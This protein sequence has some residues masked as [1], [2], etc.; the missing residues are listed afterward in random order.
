MGV[1]G[2]PGASLRGWREYFPDA[3]IYG[4]D[5]DRRILFEEKRIQTFFMDQT[6]PETIRRLWNSLLETRFDVFIDDGLHGF[7]AAQATFDAS[8]DRVRS[9]GLYIIEDVNVKEAGRYL[10]MIAARGCNGLSIEIFHPTNSIDN[11]LV[12]AC[13]AAQIPQ[14][15]RGRMFHWGTTS[16]A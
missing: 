4:G 5:I 10:D 7:E 2:I 13:G 1:H 14:E 15:K 3:R 11:C 12:V 6:R 16:K 8:F 9:G